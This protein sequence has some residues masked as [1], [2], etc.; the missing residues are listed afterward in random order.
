[1]R[2]CPEVQPSFTV[3]KWCVIITVSLTDNLWSFTITTVTSLLAVWEEEVRHELCEVKETGTCRCTHTVYLDSV[4]HFRRISLPPMS[5]TTERWPSSVMSVYVLLSRSTCHIMCSWR[6]TSCCLSVSSWRS[7]SRRS[8]WST[9]WIRATC[10]RLWR[11]RLRNWSWL[12]HSTLPWQPGPVT[13]PQ[14]W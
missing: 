10:R 14:T 5:I 2:I 1:M 11:G 12:W 4:R 7:S 3:F 8:S 9:L 13:Q 6:I